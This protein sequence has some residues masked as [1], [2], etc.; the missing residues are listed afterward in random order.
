MQNSVSTCRTWYRRHLQGAAAYRRGTLGNVLK[1]F[2]AKPAPSLDYA[3]K[4][5]KTH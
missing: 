3:A 5:F 2:A 4:T 1:P